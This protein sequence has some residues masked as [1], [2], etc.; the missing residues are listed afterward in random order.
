MYVDT[1]SAHRYQKN[2][3]RPHSLPISLSQGSVSPYRPDEIISND[4]VHRC[5]CEK[6]STSTFPMPIEEDTR[7]FHSHSWRSRFEHG[8]EFLTQQGSG[9]VPRAPRKGSLI[10][11]PR[12]LMPSTLDSE[13]FQYEFDITSSRQKQ[14]DMQLPQP[15]NLETMSELDTQ[16]STELLVGNEYLL[17]QR[18]VLEDFSQVSRCLHEQSR[19]KLLQLPM[20]ATVSTFMSRLP[21]PQTLATLGLEALRDVLI[22]CLPTSDI[23][24]FAAIHVAYTCA[25]CTTPQHLETI[26]E[27]LFYNG[28]D[29]SQAVE[30]NERFPLATVIQQIWGP[31]PRHP[32]VEPQENDVIS[33]VE[34]T[35]R[36]DKS[37]GLPFPSSWHCSAAY[38]TSPGVYA[39]DNKDIL[40]SL[41]NGYMVRIFKQFLDGMHP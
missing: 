23:K 24:I 37:D 17:G 9:A 12:D 8:L 21:E 33:G 20:L 39:Q 25:L 19:Y 11:E 30:N 10:K 4:K 16:G 27:E 22:G 3:T 14:Q 38:C 35:A 29:W 34:E 26:H 28:M 15:G 31:K 5:Y 18:N 6:N 1:D 32:R 41:Q 7:S 2:H 36:L 40:N 13:V